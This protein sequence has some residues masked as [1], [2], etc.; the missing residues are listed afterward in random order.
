MFFPVISIITVDSWIA[1]QLWII[2]SDEVALISTSFVSKHTTM[3]FKPVNSRNKSENYN[4]YTKF[5]RS[6]VYLMAFKKLY[7][8]I[9]EYENNYY[10]WSPLKNKKYGI[11]F[12]FLLL[13]ILMHAF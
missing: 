10:I 5:K 2:C 4:H 1:I 11:I 7:W 9:S 8:L 6:Q 13:I 12:S 3:K